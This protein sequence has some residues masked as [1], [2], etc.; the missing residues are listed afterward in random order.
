MMCIKFISKYHSQPQVMRWTTG[1]GRCQRA[2]LSM[3][4]KSTFHCK[5][6]REIGC[7]LRTKPM[8][9]DYIFEGL[10]I[11]PVHFILSIQQYTDLPVDIF[12]GSGLHICGQRN[13]KCFGKS[14]LLRRCFGECLLST[15]THAY[16]ELG[17]RYIYHNWSRRTGDQLSLSRDHLDWLVLLC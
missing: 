3:P 16:T 6:C 8:V 4:T 11:W 5:T 1:R 17:A 10:V 12:L 7:K 13:R 15:Y 14:L 2:Q 9:C